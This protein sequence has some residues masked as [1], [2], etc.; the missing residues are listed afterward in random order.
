MINNKALLIGV[1]IFLLAHIIT[2]FQLNGQFF[3]AWFKNN[4]AILALFGIPISY[5]YIYG[6]KYC[7]EGFGG[8]IWPG[9]FIGFAVGMVV[10][11]LFASL[12]MNEGVT[13]KTGVSLTLSLALVGVQIFWK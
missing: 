1:G 9:R 3:S 8:L 4:N 7:Y 10:F 12:I 2:W 13:M 11:S 6:T 5:L